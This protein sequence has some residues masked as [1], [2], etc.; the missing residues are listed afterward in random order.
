MCPE[1]RRP[2]LIQGGVN[3]FQSFQGFSLL[4]AADRQKYQEDFVF[5]L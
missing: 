3:L 5:F 2:E 1:S 4:F